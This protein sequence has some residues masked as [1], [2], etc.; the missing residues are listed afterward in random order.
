MTNAIVKARDGRNKRIHLKDIVPPW[1]YDTRKIDLCAGRVGPTAVYRNRTE[2]WADVLQDIWNN[3]SK[4]RSPLNYL[5]GAVQIDGEDKDGNYV[6][7][8]VGLKRKNQ[9]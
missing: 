2:T 7:R 8:Y 3:P 9:K 6:Y 5:Q 4:Q 1:A